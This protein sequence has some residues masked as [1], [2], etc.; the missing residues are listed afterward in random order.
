MEASELRSVEWW[1]PED[2]RMLEHTV[3]TSP[4]F[5]RVQGLGLRILKCS[6]TQMDKLV[7]WTVMSLQLDIPLDNSLSLLSLYRD[8]ARNTHV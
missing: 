8:V 5:Y 3:P 7:Q 6:S 4:G 2:P 1:S